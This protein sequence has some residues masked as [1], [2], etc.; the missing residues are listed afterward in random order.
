MIIKKNFLN[1]EDY[2]K[3]KEEI[4]NDKF[5]WYFNETS[6]EDEN[7][8]FQFTHRFLKNGITSSP[9]NILYP[10]LSKLKALTF[11]RINANLNTA[12][13]KIIETGEHIDADGRFKSAIFFL[14][15][16]NGY[17]KIGNKKIKSEDNKILIF[18]SSEKHTGSTC[19]DS[20]RRMLINIVYLER[21]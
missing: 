11:L 6:I 10:L 7:S 3:I 4:S 19:T 13:N 21:K 8:P 9:I 5:P 17:C 14:N 16:C 18:K 15:E 1:L 12:T 20:K 2:Q